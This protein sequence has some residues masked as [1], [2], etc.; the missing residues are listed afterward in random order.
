MAKTIAYF[1]HEHW[2]GSGYPYGLREEEIPLAAR[3]VSLADFY[4]SLT[5]ELKYRP[6]CLHEEAIRIITGERS[7]RFAPDI[8]DSLL[9][10]RHLFPAVREKFAS[11]VS[12]NNHLL[13]SPCY[14]QKKHPSDEIMPDFKAHSE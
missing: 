8:V 5:T 11:D 3:I 12:E 10:C 9:E 13:P 4:D 2:D 7:R 14:R 6:A 1:H